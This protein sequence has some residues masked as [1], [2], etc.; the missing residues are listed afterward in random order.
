MADPYPPPYDTGVSA[1]PS[2]N[3]PPPYRTSAPPATPAPEQRGG[4]TIGDFL[5]SEGKNALNEAGQA[6]MSSGPYI[7]NRLQRGFSEAMQ[8][9]AQT[10]P[11]TGEKFWIDPISKQRTDHPPM[12]TPDLPRPPGYVGMAAGAVGSAA[13]SFARDPA[14]FMLSPGAATAGS[15]VNEFGQGFPPWERE[16]VGGTLG[17]LGGPGLYNLA[18]SGALA[19]LG[20]TIGGHLGLPHLGHALG[21][22]P[23]FVEAVGKRLID[24][25]SWG[26]AITSGWV[27]GEDRASS[28]PGRTTNQLQP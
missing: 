3:Y 19:R 5:W 24:P 1:A 10:D 23:G 4:T 22:L 21:T 25:A 26:K 11:K 15:V 12:Y 13:E 18:K 14:W 6:A 20:Q 8:P 27:A 16:L 28:Q 17:L 2:E 9:S 7:Y